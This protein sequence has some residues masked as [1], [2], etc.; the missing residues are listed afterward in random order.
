MVHDRPQGPSFCSI[1]YYSTSI[2]IELDLSAKLLSLQ[3]ATD[4][5]T[6]ATAGGRKWD[7]VWFQRSILQKADSGLCTSNAGVQTVN[8]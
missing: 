2:S 3:D 8:N 4:R 7:P 1:L 6:T 5:L